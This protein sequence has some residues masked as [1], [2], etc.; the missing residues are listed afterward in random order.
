MD[1]LSPDALQHRASNP[2]SSIWV[3]ANAGS[4]KTKVLVDRVLRLLLA[5]NA[6]SRIL[7]ITFTKNAAAE[8]QARIEKELR[9]W[10]VMDDA[11]LAD[12][13]QR[14]NGAP[15]DSA[16]RIR[17]RMLFSL[18]REEVPGL[19][20]QTIHG[21]CQSLLER[22]PLEAG[23]SP[24]FQLAEDDR[25]LALLHRSKASFMSALSS[26][27]EDNPLFH[28]VAFLSSW[29]EFAAE[30][31]IKECITR[32]HVLEPWLEQYTLA[33]YEADKVQLTGYATTFAGLKEALWAFD[34]E[35][36]KRL[37]GLC[38]ILQSGKAQDKAT[39]EMLQQ[40]FAR[41]Y[42]D[43]VAI[44]ALMKG[45]F[46]D[47]GKGTLRAKLF[48]DGVA[49]AVP[50]IAAQLDTLVAAAIRYRASERQLRV[51]TESAAARVIVKMFYYFYGAIKQEHSI[52]DFHDL[53]VKAR[54][55]LTRSDMMEWVLFKLDGGIDHLLLD[56]A[57][58]TSPEQWDL[59]LK[60]V[61]EFFSGNGAREVQRTF[62]VVGDQKQ[63][64][65]SF[66]GANP[67]Y[68]RTM[69]QHLHAM[70]HASGQPFAEVPM[71]VSF[72][73][74]NSI[75][76]V[77]DAALQQAMPE[78]DA[79]THS[80]YHQHRGS[81][82]ELWPELVVEKE[83]DVAWRL[84]DTRRVAASKELRQAQQIVQVIRSWL[85]HGRNVGGT[86]VPVAAGDILI[87]VRRRNML[88]HTLARLLKEQGIHVA[89]VDRL[90][91][92]AHIAVED[93]ISFAS[94]LLNPEDDLALAEIVMSPLYGFS[95]QELF[96]V[97]VQREGASLWAMLQSRRTISEATAFA[98]EELSHFLSRV[99]FVTPYELF[100]E[101]LIVRRGHQRFLRRMG[102]ETGEILDI[103][104]SDLLGYEEQYAAEV[105][106]QHWVQWMQ[107]RE[108]ELKREMQQSSGK[109]R[110]MTIHAAK[111]LEAPLVILPDMTSTPQD[112][113]K[114]FVDASQQ[115]WYLRS[116]TECPEPLE[117]LYQAQERGMKQEYLRLLYVAMTRPEAGLYISAVGDGKR[118]ADKECAYNVVAQAMQTM[119]G[120]TSVE[121]SA[122]YPHVPFSGKE[123]S[124]I[125]S[126]S[127]AGDA[128]A[129][130]P[131]TPTTTRAMPTYFHVPP[132]MHVEQRRF[133][134]PSRVR[135]ETGYIAASGDAAPGGMDARKRG[136]V[137]HRVL[138]L[139]PLEAG[140]QEPFITGYLTRHAAHWSEAER[141]TAREEILALVR[142]PLVAQLFSAEAQAEV[143]VVGMVDGEAYS[144]QID[145]L[146]IGE[147]DILIADFKTGI[148]P[149]EG[150]EI[151]PIYQ[152][153]M[154]IY[155]ALLKQIYPTKTI[156]CQLIYTAAPLLKEV[157]LAA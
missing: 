5:G 138:E 61:Q 153:Q 71:T 55:L 10:V 57:Q 59:V 111:G 109:V 23:V 87:L 128:K 44:H 143:P 63:S 19:R 99:D 90:V 11:A 156:R 40:C 140:G 30:N 18:V 67:E 142:S 125:L 157:P 80:A 46:I 29:G 77:V 4:G 9:K 8:M 152:R 100:S 127:N 3:T 98:V 24:S 1:A 73:S 76:H 72:R 154:E 81:V 68:Y 104:Y 62:F 145:R 149:K 89:G 52:L 35:Y 49:K 16:T 26:V 132:E 112:R 70:A 115:L 130:R 56:E 74:G 12:A 105:S 20:I 51:E 47:K 103:M 139:L 17:A 2:G 122:A 129:H 75:L 32:R 131:A 93:L 82:V 41:N 151:P 58:D 78:G 84:P 102:E 85:M 34:P 144:G 7:C 137:I 69:L 36:I 135:E 146:H 60:L 97:A 42:Y 54:N 95:Q 141:V 136:D 106:L 114:L 133:L 53:I 123:Q 48:N 66:Q 22:F 6:P 64:I 83:E 14:L 155:H 45:L 37:R 119:P 101:L 147:S 21:F 113:D 120:V 86:M 126:V 13:L 92:N 31:I 96:D 50:D 88:V 148:P 118:K 117:H 79:V 110:I 116:K 134:S 150:E 38:P 25:Q 33:Q 43:D 121:W 91:L 39:G 27:E 124:A 107:G 108:T 94:F 65:F 28:A 15:P